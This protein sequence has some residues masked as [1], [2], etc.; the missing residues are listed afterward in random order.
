MERN[1]EETREASQEN[2]AVLK[3]KE[4]TGATR[5]GN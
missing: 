1:K 2:I 3:E 4:I 5:N